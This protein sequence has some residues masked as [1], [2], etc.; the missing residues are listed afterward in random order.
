[1]ITIILIT[2]TNICEKWSSSRLLAPKETRVCQ[3]S[4]KGGAVEAGCSDLYDVMYYFIVGYYPHPLHP[5]HC[6][7]L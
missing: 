6:T 4:S 3:D 1:M 7:P 5:S 2:K